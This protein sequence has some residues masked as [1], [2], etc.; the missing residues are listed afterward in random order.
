MLE[1]HPSPAVRDW[2]FSIFAV[3]L[4]IWMPY[5]LFAKRGRVMPW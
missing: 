3:A 2:L 4:R 5:P 1:D